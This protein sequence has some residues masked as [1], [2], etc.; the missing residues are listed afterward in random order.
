MHT[1]RVAHVA[2]FGCLIAPALRA[3][4]APREY[5]PAI[6]VT[7]PIWHGF[8]VLLLEEQHLAMHDLA[9]TDHVRGVGLQSPSFRYGF[10]AVELREVRRTNGLIEH[11]WVPAINTVTELG[12]GAELRDRARVEFRDIAGTWSRRYQNRTTLLR[13]IDVRGTACAPY[14]HYELSYDTRFAVLNRREA[15]VGVRIPVGQGATVDSFLMRQTDTRRDMEAIV[16]AGVILRVA[17]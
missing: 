11:R 10:L 7:L 8:G 1:S 17:L 2:L 9:H 6:V 4:P 5:R 15:A 3:Q 16:A 14:V 13:P 12:G